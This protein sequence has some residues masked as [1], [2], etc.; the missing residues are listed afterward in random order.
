MADTP[1]RK[2][3]A[4]F[5]FVTLLLDVIG[6][7]LIIPV[8]PQLVIDMTG[9]DATTGA[10][11]YGPVVALYAAMQFIFAPVLGVLSDRYGRRPVILLSLLGFGLNY[12][13]LAFAPNLLWLIIGRIVAG[14]TGATI[15]A[16]NAYLADIST[17]ETRARNFGLVG[18]AFGVGFIL[19][20]A[21]GGMLGE[22][23][24]RVPFLVS[25]GVVLIN[26]LWGYFVLPE[27]LP[28]SQRK[29]IQW[30]RANPLR[31]VGRLRDY[32][33]VGR[34]AVAFVLSTLAQRGL[35]SV[36]VLHGTHRYGWSEMENGLTL[37]LVGLMTV[38]I[39]GGVIRVAVPRLGERRAIL[40]GLGAASLGNMLWGLSGASWQALAV[41]PLASLG[42]L[43]MP[44]LQG[45][46]AGAV[47]QS[48]Q[49]SVQGALTS[50][51][52]LTAIV[53][54]LISTGLFSHFTREAA[55]V[56]VPGAPFFFGGTCMAAA[57]LVAAWAL[58]GGGVVPPTSGG[59]VPSGP[60]APGDPAPRS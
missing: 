29:P 25:A 52:S 17:P 5:I 41:I 55:S 3:A 44:T 20:P 16:A 57:L 50:V 47:P 36:W 30:S 21:A 42:G 1:P 31:T 2:A 24:I 54:P 8:L 49:G 14:I 53:A 51:L 12:L 60:G 10:R 13:I 6:I 48:E 28:E 4:R 45:V 11:W 33:L 22:I 32:P 59:V 23:G 37:A 18:A 26:A 39:Q 38:I 56:K 46:A 34:L 9:G 15:T 19:G 35:E 58:D 40:L 7:G 27:S 43:A